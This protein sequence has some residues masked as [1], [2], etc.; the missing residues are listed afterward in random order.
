MQY[1][2]ERPRLGIGGPRNCRK[3]QLCLIRLDGGIERNCSSLSFPSVWLVSPP[4]VE[5]EEPARS[6]IMIEIAPVPLRT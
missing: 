1:A 5:G 6:A 2:Y 3:I 4:E